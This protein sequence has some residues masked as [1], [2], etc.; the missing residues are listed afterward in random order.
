MSVSAQES[1]P[2][3]RELRLRAGLSQRGLARVAGVAS[4]TVRSAELGMVPRPELQRK[5]ADALCRELDEPVA[6]FDLFPLIVEDA[7]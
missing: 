5:L 3:L 7:A 1:S 6:I 4:N 2:R